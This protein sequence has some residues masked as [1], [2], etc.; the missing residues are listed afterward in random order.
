MF[1]QALW[2]GGSDQEDEGQEVDLSKS[3]AGA[4]LKKEARPLLIERDNSS[5]ISLGK[6]ESVSSERTLDEG[7]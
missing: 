1:Q 4:G 2:I 6:E 7:H 5:Y 3:T